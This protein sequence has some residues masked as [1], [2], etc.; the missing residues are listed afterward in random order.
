MRAFGNRRPRHAVEAV[1]SG[2]EV[3]GQFVRGAVVLKANARRRRIEIVQRQVFDFM[4][5]RTSG[6][7]PCRVQIFL[8]FVLTVDRDG[9]A[10]G[11]L[12]HVDAMARAAEADVDAVMDEALAPH[13]VAESD[14]VEQIDRALFE[15]AGA[16]AVDH[17]F[18]AP[19][20]EDH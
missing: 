9:A 16:D 12:V 14:G 20:F 11:Q 18:L 1:A 7:P 2:D 3:A 19:R 13:A 8:Q 15:D 17:V 5:Q 10:A 4:Q 6:G